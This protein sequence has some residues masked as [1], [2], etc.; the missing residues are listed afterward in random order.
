M[1]SKNRDGDKVRLL[2]ILHVQ[3]DSLN[4]FIVYLHCSHDRSKYSEQ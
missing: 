1:G 4:F 3:V 2:G